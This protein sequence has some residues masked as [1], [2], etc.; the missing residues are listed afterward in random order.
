MQSTLLHVSSYYY[1]CVLIRYTRSR[2]NC[3]VLVANQVSDALG[4]DEHS[5]AGDFDARNQDSERHRKSVEETA[6]DEDGPGTHFTC[7]LLV[8]KYKH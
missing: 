8:Q 5:K 2:Y 7:F 3:A 1:I 6:R 4:T